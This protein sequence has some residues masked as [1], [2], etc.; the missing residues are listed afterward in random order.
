M[1]I[2]LRQP[3]AVHRK[4]AKLWGVHILGR[5]SW[6]IQVY[7]SNSVEDLRRRQRCMMVHSCT[8]NRFTAG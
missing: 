8:R 7:S 3:K 1:E 2:P 5:I 4:V 6:S